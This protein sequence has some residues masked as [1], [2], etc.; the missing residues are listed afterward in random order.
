MA[1][2]E[3]TKDNLQS[4]IR[5]NEILLIDFWAEWC[6]PCKMFGPIFRKAAEEHPHLGFG[7]CDVEAQQEVAGMF[8]VRSIPTLGIF[9]EQILVFSQPGA[10][11]QEALT[12][13]IRKVEQL[14]M[15]DVRRRI[16]EQEAAKEESAPAP[17]RQKPETPGGAA[18]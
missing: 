8:G 9:K 6:G 12:D 13:I 15:A 17:G 3:L 11:P 1:Y 5:D 10:L 2:F 16:A 18:S 14:D 4:A 7:S